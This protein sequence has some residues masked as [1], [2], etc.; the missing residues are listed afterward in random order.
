MEVIKKIKKI[1]GKTPVIT[2]I[3]THY[4]RMVEDGISE[5]ECGS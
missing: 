3:K 5:F 2:G 4:L 1:I